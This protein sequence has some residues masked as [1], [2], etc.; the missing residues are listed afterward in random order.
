MPAKRASFLLEQGWEP[1]QESVRK[2]RV[3]IT[4]WRDPLLTRH[5]GGWTEHKVLWPHEAEF[6]AD[7]RLA[8]VR[9]VM[10]D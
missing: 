10:E 3:P 8:V 4:M 1:V 2:D 9:S 6:R 7:M 5:A